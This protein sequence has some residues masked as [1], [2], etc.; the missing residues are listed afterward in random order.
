MKS[1]TLL[2]SPGAAIGQRL[3]AARSQSGLTIEQLAK[4]S[5]VSPGLLSL[6]ERGQGNPS[7]NTLVKLAEALAMPISDFFPTPDPAARGVVRRGERKLLQ[8]N[9]EVTYQLLTPDLRGAIELIYTELE[10]NVS[11]GP[12]RHEGEE[13]GILLEG[14]L[15]VH[16][17]DETVVLEAGDSIRYATTI[18]HSYTNPG[19]ERATMIWAITPPYF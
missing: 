1:D 3:R 2:G 11:V 17:G 16:L 6:L 8:F 14:V 18:P 19:P 7:V 13:A 15:H 12:F 5:G 9:H 4:R 10:P